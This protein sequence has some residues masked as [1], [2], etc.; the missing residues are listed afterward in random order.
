MAAVFDLREVGEDLNGNIRIWSRGWRLRMQ[1][2]HQ[3]DK[4][5]IKGVGVCGGDTDHQDSRVS[6]TEQILIRQAG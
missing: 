6:A 1:R 5:Q 4:G 3:D 2:N